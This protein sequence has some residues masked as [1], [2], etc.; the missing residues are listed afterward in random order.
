MKKTVVAMSS[1]IIVGLMMAMPVSAGSQTVTFCDREGDLG[2]P[3]GYSAGQGSH[4]WGDPYGLWSGAAPLAQAGYLDMLSGWVSL[5]GGKV[6]MGLT[7]ASPLPMEG[8]LPVSVVE[9]LWA[10]FFYQSI[11]VYYGGGRAPYAVY[12]MWDGVH[13]SAA[14]VDRTS[15]TLPYAVTYL[16]TFTA[17]GNV[18]TVTVSL[19]SIDGAIAWFSE[20]IAMYATPWPLD[21]VHQYGGWDAPD[22]TDFQ[23]PLAI[24]WPWQAMP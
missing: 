21:G 2:V 20:T 5:K 6:T 1:M 24:Y 22:L 15:G 10:W 16:D 4:E 12:V 3:A 18:L 17:S 8:E 7:T 11:D 9:V 14:L 23:G 13:F 19:A